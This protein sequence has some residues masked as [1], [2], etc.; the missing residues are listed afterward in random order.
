MISEG[1]WQYCALDSGFWRSLSNPA[2]QITVCDCSWHWCLWTSKKEISRY[3]NKTQE[4]K[5]YIKKQ[6]NKKKANTKLKT[7]SCEW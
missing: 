1:N 2:Q 4:P 6:A 3:V 7:F 5:V